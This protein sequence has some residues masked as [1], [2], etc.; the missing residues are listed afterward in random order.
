MIIA[1]VAKRILRPFAAL[2]ARAEIPAAQA[3]ATRASYE[4][5][6]P[7][8]NMTPIAAGGVPPS[9]QDFNGILYDVSNAAM[10]QQ[11][12][13]ILPWSAEFAQSAVSGGYPKNALVVHNAALYQSAIDNNPSEPGADSNW[14]GVT[15]ANAAN[16]QQ[17]A[18]LGQVVSLSAGALPTGMAGFFFSDTAPVGWLKANGAEL[19]RT[20][21]AKLFAAIGTRYGE[22]DGS[23]T[24]KLPDMRGYFPRGWDDGRG[25]DSGRALGSTQI[26]A[27]R[28]IHGSIG[29]S[30]VVGFFQ[31]GTGAFLPS[32]GSLSVGVGKGGSWKGQNGFDF[33]SGRAG[34]PTANEIRPKNMALLAC[35]KY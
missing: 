6:F 19:S 17:A 8:L 32:G 15:V 13:G 33:D 11:A 25:I 3:D 10:W 23:T 29:S 16:D 14:S 12:A 20:T 26:D 7:A 35:I 34:I 21:Y 24:F 27:M 28:L 5:G 31:T 22:G 1:N 2:G 9:G 30:D 4:Q 18:T